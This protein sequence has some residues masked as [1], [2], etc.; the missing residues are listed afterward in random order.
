MAWLESVAVVWSMP[1]APIRA[2]VLWLLVELMLIELMVVVL[3]LVVIH[4]MR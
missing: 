2:L 4:S 1:V 3:L